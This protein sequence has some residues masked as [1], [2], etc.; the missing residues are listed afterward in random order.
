MLPWY[1]FHLKYFYQ[2]LNEWIYSHPDT[3][4]YMVP[5]VEKAITLG[6][7]QWNQD[8]TSTTK[9]NRDELWLWKFGSNMEKVE[10][11]YAVVSECSDVR[12]DWRATIF[13]ILIRTH[14]TRRWE[15]ALK[16]KRV[17][18]RWKHFFKS[19]KTTVYQRRIWLLKGDFSQ[20]IN[21]MM[22][23]ST[24]TSHNWGTFHL[25]A[26]LEMPKMD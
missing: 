1:I 15:M 18:L 10:A 17:I 5:G 8:G 20:E 25:H 13:N 7:D 9:T 12:K 26:N 19:L 21:H 2:D 24:H 11:N 22:K 23:Q 4:Y 6:L 16:L 14:G 3:I